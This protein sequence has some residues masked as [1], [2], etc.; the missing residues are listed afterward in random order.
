MTARTLITALTA[1]AALAAAS[2]AAAA[3]AP[4]TATISTGA[5]RALS[6]AHVAFPLPAGFTPQT[7]VNGNV[8][9]G[10]YES[11][12]LMGDQPR[13]Y[14]GFSAG[15]RAQRM[16]PV[17]PATTNRGHVGAW[18]WYLRRDAGGNWLG[19]AW[20]KAPS[21]LA[22]KRRR[23]LTFTLGATYGFAASYDR[24]ECA[25]VLPDPVAAARSAIRGVRAVR[26]R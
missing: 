1:A 9:Q 23:Y 4:I 11:V 26:A 18:R 5:T 19:H 22:S 2:P 13:C 14:A 15:G 8:M 3:R 20:R 12:V 17:P 10:Q 16:R 6:W 25:A 24:P 7:S 21:W